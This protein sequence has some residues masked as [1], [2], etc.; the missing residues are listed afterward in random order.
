[1]FRYSNIHQHLIAKTRISNTALNT[2]TPIH[3]QNPKR[4]KAGMRVKGI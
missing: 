2:P 4:I 1:M 3:S